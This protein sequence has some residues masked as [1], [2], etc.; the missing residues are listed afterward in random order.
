ML[1]PV[2]VLLVLVAGCASMETRWDTATSENT[3]EAFEGFLAWHPDGEYAPAAREKIESLRWREATAG[4]TVRGFELYL[5]H[6][7]EGG[8]AAEAR[9]NI[10]SIRWR[11]AKAKN[12]PY[13]LEIFLRKHPN[14][15]YSADARRRLEE[16]EWSIARNG[17]SFSGYKAFADKYPQSKYSSEARSLLKTFAVVVA[18]S[19]G[20]VKSRPHYKNI[21]GPVWV[22]TITFR[23]TNG[24]AAIITEKRIRVDTAFRAWTDWGYRKIVSSEPGRQGEVGVRIPPNG[25]GAYMSFISGAPL[26]WGKMRV[27]FIGTDANGHAIKTSVEF[28]LER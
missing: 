27:D 8:H 7:P 10:E 25:A 3:I 12:A 15:R 28:T 19:P 5:Q 6:H 9:D 18:E 17:D 14:S 26:S 16:V 2:V 1:L 24:V 20:S 23:E 11:E 4:D 22:Y 21:L 13:A